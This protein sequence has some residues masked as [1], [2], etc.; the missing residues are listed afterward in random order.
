MGECGCGGDELRA[1]VRA[2][3][4]EIDEGSAGARRVREGFDQGLEAGKVLV[5][6]GDFRQFWRRGPA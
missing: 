1:G 5:R 6:A 2:F 3:L 4:N